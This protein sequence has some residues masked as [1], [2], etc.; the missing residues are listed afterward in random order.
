MHALEK[1]NYQLEQYLV[2]TVE[3]MV[4]DSYKA[5]VLASVRVINFLVLEWELCLEL[6]LSSLE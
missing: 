5:V 2:L 3:E 1:D 6:P 4:T